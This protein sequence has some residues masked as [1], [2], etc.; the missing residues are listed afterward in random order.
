MKA[1]T[2][3]NPA[4]SS[5]V[6]ICRT[7]IAAR[8]LLAF[9]LLFAVANAVFGFAAPPPLPPQALAFMGGLM[10]SG[11]F[12]ALLKGTEFVVALALLTN[13]FVPLALIVL[14]PIT[15]NIIL[16]HALLAPEGLPIAVILLVLHLVTA[17]SYRDSFRQVLTMK[18]A[19]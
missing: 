14:A 1:A 10:G 12:F 6:W 18:P 3:A 4:K 7:Y 16:F 19:C 9:L 15:V 8:F 5:A 17:W 13:C 11:Y 2:T